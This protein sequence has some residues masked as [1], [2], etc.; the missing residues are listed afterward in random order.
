MPTPETPS[1]ASSDE[2]SAVIGRRGSYAKG[3]AR[4]REILDRALEVFRERGA[5]GTSLR[6]IAE[7]IGVSHG[8][9]LH[10]FHSREQLLLAVYE[11]AEAQR[12]DD[13]DAPPVHGAVDTLVEAATRNVHVPGLVQ[14]YS[15][16]L[17][18]S[19][20]EEAAH[21]GPPGG[22]EG[23]AFFTER[24]ARLRRDLAGRLA[25]QQAEGSV[26]G[27]VD[28]ERVAALLIAASDGLQIQ[29]LLEP[30]I[31]LES[32]LEEFAVLLRPAS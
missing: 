10:Y 28:P 20:E 3:V 8:A 14:L 15:T 24:F 27:D 13:P 1:G 18:A 32:T 26:R 25:L 9:L 2:T 30:S 21:G 11:H 23:T 31:P 19:L 12:R 22:R 4:R 5:E 29:W 6:R 16:L 7:A 17:A